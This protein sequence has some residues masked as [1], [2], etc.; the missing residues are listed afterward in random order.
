MNH[1]DV[2]CLKPT[3]NVSMNLIFDLWSYRDENIT[4]YFNCSEVTP[5]PIKTLEDVVK[6]IFM[7]NV[8]DDIIED[9]PVQKDEP[10]MNNAHTNSPPTLQL[11]EQLNT[12]PITIPVVTE[13]VKQV[14]SSVNLA[15]LLV[16]N[17]PMEMNVV[18]S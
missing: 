11:Y 2:R 14:P 10:E 6:D 9:E 15:S 12:E 5:I 18:F 7:F 4:V 17:D 1:F 3:G 13:A 8:E 16:P